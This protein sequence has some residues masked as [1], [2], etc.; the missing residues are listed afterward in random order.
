[1]IYISSILINLYLQ[2]EPPKG[3]INEDDEN[4]FISKTKTKIEE[5]NLTKNAK[6][7]LS[8]EEFSKITCI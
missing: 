8:K 2:E 3:K 1:L 4:L 7:T 5:G 6:K